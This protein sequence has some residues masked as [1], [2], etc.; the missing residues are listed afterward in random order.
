MKANKKLI[1]SVAALLIPLSA[2][3]AG[4]N[5]SLPVLKNTVELNEK[6]LEAIKVL[7]DGGVIVLKADG[8]VIINK[9]L[10]IEDQL[11]DLGI[12]HKTHSATGGWCY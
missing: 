2:S 3:V 6:E 4:E 1:T 5:K 8:K 12:L 9:N 10:S 7:I 11:E